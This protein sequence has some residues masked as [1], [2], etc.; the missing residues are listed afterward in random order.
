MSVEL[1]RIST[2]VAGLDEIMSAGL[3]AHQAYLIKGQLG[4]GKTTCV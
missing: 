1:K 3:I 2:G 4:S